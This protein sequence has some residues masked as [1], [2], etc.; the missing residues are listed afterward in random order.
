MLDHISI[1][2][3]DLD[4]SVEFYDAVLKPL[5]YIR[6]WSNVEAAGYGLPGQSDE[7]FAIK[8]E[9]AGRLGSSARSH[10]AFVSPDRQ[11]VLAFYAAALASGATDDGMPGIH[12]EYGPNYFAAFVVDPNGYRLEA[13]CHG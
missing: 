1:G 12:A 9:C 3:S 13:V 4:R 6:L 2:V 11:S 5:G 7:P 10:V 8:R